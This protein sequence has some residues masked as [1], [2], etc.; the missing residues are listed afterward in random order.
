MTI[1]LTAIPVLME[2]YLTIKS[3]HLAIFPN[4]ISK[5]PYF[6]SG[7]DIFVLWKRNGKSTLSGCE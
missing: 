5:I 4:I 2:S 1:K 3:I 7:D 6:V